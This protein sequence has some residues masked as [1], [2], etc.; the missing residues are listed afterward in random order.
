MRK[1]VTIRTL[2]SEL[3]LS[4][5]A[6]SKALN[7][8]PD[9]G[10][11]TKALV[12]RKAEELGYTP[13]LL[14]R[15]L[16][17]KTS[18]F[19]GVVI[20]DVSSVY[21][22]MFKSLSEVARRY[23]LHLILYDTN[24][25]AAVE[26]WC[27]QNLID[28]VA[29]G[30]VIVPVSEDVDEICTMAKGRVPVVFL[31]GKVRDNAFNYVSADSRVGTEMA[32]RHLI[33]LGHERIAMVFDYKSSNSRS[34][35]LEVYRQV[36]RE[37]GQEERVFY[38]SGEDTD[39]MESGYVQGRRILTSGA[40]ITA[41][42]AVKDMMAIGVVRAFQEAGKRVPED[43]SV[44]GYDGI[45]AAALPM[46]GL[47]TVAQPRMEMAE[48]IIDILNRHASDPST[49]PEHYLAKPELIERKSSAS[50]VHMLESIV[51]AV[52]AVQGF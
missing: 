49:P 32:L 42:F 2:A 45:D 26:K 33:G 11:E 30:I 5:S 13:N 18:P 28:S 47:T 24:N 20:R 34:T 27:V 41:V 46:I 39:I 52:G 51:S 7:D 4:V 3:G 48:R 44:V 21:G 38:G 37:L 14:A 19:V 40:N 1:P 31:G 12:Q 25:D 8:Y 50:P 9:I 6:V 23:G 35:K 43:V 29:M 36:M 16:A 22:E 15:N 10:T 17:K